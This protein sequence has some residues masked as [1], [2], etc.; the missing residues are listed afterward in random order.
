[1]RRTGIVLRKIR[2]RARSSW[3]T[4]HEAGLFFPCLA[5]SIALGAAAMTALGKTEVAERAIAGSW[6]IQVFRLGWY[7]LALVMVIIMT[8]ALH[9]IARMTVGQSLVVLSSAWERRQRLKRFRTYSPA[10]P[11]ETHRSLLEHIYGHAGA[12]GLRSVLQAV[13][14]SK[15]CAYLQFVAGSDALAKQLSVEQRRMKPPIPLPGGGC[16]D[17]GLGELLHPLIKHEYLVLRDD[18]WHLDPAFLASL[19]RA[20]LTCR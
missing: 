8:L 10:I 11:I 14:H 18:G 2:T 13:K 20:T 6:A 17:F 12:G 3:L 16:I 19:E 7:P 9:M 5:I 15:D 1:M 4:S